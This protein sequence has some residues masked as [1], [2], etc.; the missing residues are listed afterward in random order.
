V[1]SR[2]VIVTC[3]TSHTYNH[4]D[5]PDVVF[6][7]DKCDPERRVPQAAATTD[8]V[9][10]ISVWRQASEAVRATTTGKISIIGA[11]EATD[12]NETYMLGYHEFG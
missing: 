9:A 3:F 12:F 6:L 4:D 7:F 2:V 5:T 8:A 1:F 11:M 10:I